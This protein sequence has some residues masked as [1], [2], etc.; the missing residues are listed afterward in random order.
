MIFR[1]I[2]PISWWNSTVECS[3]MNS[4]HQKDQSRWKSAPKIPEKKKI[5]PGGW[6]EA[7]TSFIRIPLIV[8]RN[9]FV[10]N[11][12]KSPLNRKKTEEK[13][14]KIGWIEIGLKS[15]EKIVRKK[16]DKNNWGRSQFSK[17]ETGF[18]FR[19]KMSQILKPS[20]SN[21]PDWNLIIG[22]PIHVISNR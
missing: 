7:A 21:W 18:K 8:I 10:I 13:G 16:N 3:V 17:F 19:V 15:A 11:K 4:W 9:R 22:K 12:R 1:L 5:R 6:M 2:N 20:S 14:A